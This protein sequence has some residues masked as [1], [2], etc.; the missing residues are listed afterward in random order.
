MVRPMM[1]MPLFTGFSKATLSAFFRTSL[2]ALKI[3]RLRRLH[4]RTRGRDMGSFD[5]RDE[6]AI[7]LPYPIY[8]TFDVLGVI[9]QRLD[10]EE[11]RAY[12]CP[13]EI[14]HRLLFFFSF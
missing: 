11:R 9:E 14:T 3:S 10:D 7:A 12:L 1:V 13:N 2:S 5:A 8:S 6:G 4:D